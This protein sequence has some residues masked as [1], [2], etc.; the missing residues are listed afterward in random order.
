MASKRQLR[1]EMRQRLVQYDLADMQRAGLRI[2]AALEVLLTRYFQPQLIMSYVSTKGEA[3][4][5]DV[6]RNCLQRGQRICVPKIELAEE[7][8]EPREVEN[9]YRDLQRGYH[10]ILEPGDTSRPVDADEIDIHL[11]PG[12]A[13]D[14]QGVRLGRGGGFYDRFLQQCSPEKIK[15]GLA[16][17]WQI[18]EEIPAETHDIPMDLIVTEVGVVQVRDGLLG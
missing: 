5:H 15:V 1:E 11:I 7:T 18:V 17:S 2:G 12:I 16:F 3:P 10:G 9:F 13:F 4:T 8:M 6:I 14:P